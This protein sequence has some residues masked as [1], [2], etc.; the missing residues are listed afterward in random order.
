MITLILAVSISVVVSALCSLLESVLYSTRAITLEASAQDEVREAAA[1]KR[2][3]SEVERPLSAILILNTMANTAGAALA[4]WAAGQVWGA[5]SLWPFSLA[6]TMTILICSEIVPKT[7]GA[8]HWR[9]LWRP[10]VYPLRFMVTVASPL[11][12]MT[13]AFT[14]LITGGRQRSPAISEDEILAAARLGHSGGEISKLEHDLIR[15]IISLE[16]I[17]AGDIMT[18]RTVLFSADGA[19]RVGQAQEQA[20]SW[21]HSRVPVWVGNSEEVTGYVVKDQ[22][23][24][25]RGQLLDTELRALAKPLRFVPASANA[26]DLLNSF[27]LRREQVYL[28]VDEYGGIMGV[29]TLEDVIESL[30]G[31]EIVDEKD[32]VADLRE[33]AKR[34]A[35][36][37]LDKASEDAG[38]EG[39]Q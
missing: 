12:W 8:V 19:S 22:V 33:L 38:R 24:A 5:G 11:I 3:K 30:V 18:P 10:S 16:G 31:S 1:M 25:A 13:Q 37:V 28:V 39:E 21:P 26:L 4:G 20:R 9:K 15:N 32:P 34:R 35:Q 14:R 17:K 27:L 2:F 6:F 23:L 7:V 36:P 29:V